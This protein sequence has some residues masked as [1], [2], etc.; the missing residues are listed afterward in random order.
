MRLSL[1]VRLALTFSVIAVLSLSV[2]GVTLFSAL[3]R[4]VY[5][6]DDLGIVLATRH[7]RR[8]ATELDTADDVRVH[9]ERLVSLVLGDPALAM[10]IETAAGKAL[11]DYDPPQIRMIALSATPATERIVT[12]QI[13]RWAAAGAIPVRGVASKA[14]L[15]DGSSVKISV[16]R[17]MGDRAQLLDYY[18]NV[19]W[20][21]VGSAGLI[22]VALCYFLVRRA[23]APLRVIVRSAHAITAEHLDSHIDVSGAPPEL[24]DLAQS[25]NAMLQRLKQG[26][27]RLWQFTA[28][29]AHDLR[30]PIGN[31][32]GASEVAL[33]RSRSTADYQALLVSNIEECDRVSRMIENVLFLARAESPQFALRR[34][35]FDAG[36]ELARIAEYFE[37]VSAEAGVDVRVAGQARLYA[38]SELFRRAVSN[39]L[40]NALR[41]TPRGKAVSMTAAE[42]DQGVSIRVENPGEGIA[43]QD[44]AKVFDR[45]YRGDKARSNS[46]G[47]TGLGLAI[48]KTIVEIHGGTARAS[49]EAGGITIFELRFPPCRAQDS[50]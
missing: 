21:T 5:Q 32:R 35:V 2:V 23:L 9:Q 18:R 15:H 13:Q 38:D 40:A 33:T 43:P 41:Y 46:G 19:I 10:R 4:Q 22:A 49:S 36:H 25:L 12:E 37:G 44:L 20:A 8:L 50:E 14:T 47:S 31:M 16:A 42:S 34:A 48:V 28:D 24:Y 26:F 3:S 11:I 39:L 6:Q 7:L 27:D 1:S 45:F 30:T 29:L 17:S